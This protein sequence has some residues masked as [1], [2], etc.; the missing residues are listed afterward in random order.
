MQEVRAL[1]EKVVVLVRH[2]VHDTR[3]ARGRE[4]GDGC[5]DHRGGTSEKRHEESGESRPEPL[6]TEDHGHNGR[7]DPTHGDLSKKCLGGA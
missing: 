3:A 6:L 2:D 7:E 1:E 5:D 4:G